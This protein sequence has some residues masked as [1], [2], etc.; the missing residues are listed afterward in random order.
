MHFSSKFG[1][2]IGGES[3]HGQAQNEVNLDFEVKFDLEDQSQSPFKTLGILTK[4]FYTY[5]LN[6][7]ILAW[8]SDE[9]S[10]GQAS[11]YRTHRW[12]DG[13]TYRQ[14]QSTGITQAKT[15]LG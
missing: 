2:S 12:T 4:A 5:G 15:G 14:T 10:R 11:A 3:W 7:V 6:F 1:N 9:L 13:H 8:T